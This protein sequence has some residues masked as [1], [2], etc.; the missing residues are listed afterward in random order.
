VNGPDINPTPEEELT[1]HDPML[2]PEELTEAEMAE[3]EF[4]LH[5]T[6]HAVDAPAGFAERV[7][8]KAAAGPVSVPAATKR[9]SST[10]VLSF[11][12]RFRSL[13]AMGAIAAGL[14]V[15]AFTGYDLHSRHQEQAQR[16]AEATQ[17]FDLATEITDRAVQ[18]AQEHAREQM[19]RAGVPKS[20]LP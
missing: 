17:Q 12:G 1:M 20:L 7:L 11:P 16:C 9:P 5:A 18:Q 13:P 19:E 10:K 14:L 2:F 4:A 6:L 15:A 3:L 8:A